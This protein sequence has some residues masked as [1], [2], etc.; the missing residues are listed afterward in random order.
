MTFQKLSELSLRVTSPTSSH[1]SSDTS[2][3]RKTPTLTP[4]LNYLVEGTVWHSTK[5]HMGCPHYICKYLVHVLALSFPTNVLLDDTPEN[6]GPGIQV[7]DTHLG[8]PEGL[9]GSRFQPDPVLTAV[10]M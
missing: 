9:L 5:C 1:T 4:L 2:Q 3:E 8:D 7:P 6:H 10:S